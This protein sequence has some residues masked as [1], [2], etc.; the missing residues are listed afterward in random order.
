MGITHA[1]AATGTDSGDGK[2]SK[3]A[4]NEDHA[5]SSLLAVC[6]YASG[7]DAVVNA[8]TTSASFADI[9][10]TNAVVTFTAPASGNVL[11]RLSALQSGDGAKIY[12]WGL[13]EA[14]SDVGTPWRVGNGSAAGVSAVGTIRLTGISSGSHTY[15]WAHRLATSGGTG[16]GIYAGPTWGQIVMEVWAAP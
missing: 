14:S 5:G 8:L 2:I 6:A 15:K 1:T 3:N 7:S 10:A 13:R 12:Y 4:W 9:D 11:V 16:T